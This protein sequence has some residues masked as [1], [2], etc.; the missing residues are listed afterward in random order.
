[1]DLELHLKWFEKD[2]SLRAFGVRSEG[3]SYHLS[4]NP[5]SFPFKKKYK[6]LYCLY[7][8][9]RPFLWRKLNSI[10]GNGTM[11][12][13]CTFPSGRNLTHPYLRNL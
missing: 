7:N 4:K 12:W 11:D 13:N 3:H 9:L 10:Q 2:A 8:I 6:F 5:S 1:M